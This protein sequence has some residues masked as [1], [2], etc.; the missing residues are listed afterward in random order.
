MNLKYAYLSKQCLY[1]NSK[2]QYIP[3]LQYNFYNFHKS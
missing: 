1:F 2:I 3:G